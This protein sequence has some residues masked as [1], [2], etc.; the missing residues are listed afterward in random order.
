M[1]HLLYLLIISIFS[2]FNPI[3][4]V[5][6]TPVTGSELTT[7]VTALNKASAQLKSMECEFVQTKNLKMLKDKMVSKGKMYYAAPDKLR[8]E[9]TNPY[10]YLFI[11]NGSKVFI[12]NKGT[13]NVI[14]TKSNKIFKE[15]ARIMMQTV[16]GKA[17]SDSNDFVISVSKDASTYF[18]SM[19]PKKRDLKQL[20]QSVTLSFNRNS[21]LI[22]CIRINEKNGDYTV[23]KLTNLKSNRSLDAKLFSIP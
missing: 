23:I 8:W 10:Q 1:K 3:I 11:F 22:D 18:V 13:Q 15:V 17:L 5:A 20:F 12:K 16:T 6:A 2:V 7:T 19:T 14:D 9:Y 21:K 4:G